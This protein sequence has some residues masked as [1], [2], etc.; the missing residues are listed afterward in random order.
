MRHRALL[1]AARKGAPVLRAMT[2]AVPVATV[3][4]CWIIG[5]QTV[6]AHEVFI[7][8]SVCM[9]TFGFFGL[10]V[11][12]TVEATADRPSETAHSADTK[13]AR[14]R[15]HSGPE[16]GFMLL[17]MVVAGVLFSIGWVMMQVMV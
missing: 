7:I 2:V 13:P 14:S 12:A 8:A 16:L 9:L 11:R 4:V 17:S 6:K 15:N 5:W 10:Y 3:L 1:A